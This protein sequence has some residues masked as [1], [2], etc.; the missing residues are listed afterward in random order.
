[1]S[2]QIT[3]YSRPKCGK[4]SKESRVKKAIRQAKFSCFI[5]RGWKGGNG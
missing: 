5:S 1:M 3:A 2:A 4:K